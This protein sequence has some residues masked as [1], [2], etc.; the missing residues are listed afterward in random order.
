[1]SEQFKATVKDKSIIGF[2]VR[3]VLTHGIDKLI[4]LE[5]KIAKS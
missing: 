5:T 1:M 3:L 2:V 4:T